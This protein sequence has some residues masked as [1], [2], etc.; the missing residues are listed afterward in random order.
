MMSE[1]AFNNFFFEKRLIDAHLMQEFGALKQDKLR[2][3]NVPSFTLFQMSVGDKDHKYLTQNGYVSYLSSPIKDKES[4]TPKNI[5][6][7]CY[8]VKGLEILKSS[9]SKQED[10]QNIII[11]ESMIDSLSLLELKEYNPKNTLLCSTNG[12]ITKTQKDVFA[13]LSKEFKDKNFYLGFDNDKKG[14]EFENISKDYFKEAKILRANFKD[15]NDDLILAKNLGLENNFKRSDCEK[16]LFEME[17]RALVFARDF[18]EYSGDEVAKKLKQITNSDIPRYERIKSKVEN[19]IDT[20]RLDFAYN[21]LSL[22]LEKEL[23]RVR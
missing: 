14:R 13:Y 1:L 22:S 3:I 2:N 9:N 10:I 4:K 12:Q 6:S 15:F 8:G 19:Y 5:K 21:K 23:G 7:L 11:T 16:L 20:T 18:K 17:K